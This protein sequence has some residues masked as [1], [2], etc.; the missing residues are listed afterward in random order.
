ML[1]KNFV[2]SI[3][4]S[5]LSIIL[6]VSCQ[7]S[8]NAGQ[9]GTS[10]GSV[11]I[12]GDGTADG[13]AIDIDGDGVAD[14]IDTD[15]DGLI[16][17]EWSDDYTISD[18]ESDST[19]GESDSTSGETDSTSGETDTTSG[20]TDT[21][22]PAEVTNFKLTNVGKCT[23]SS[24]W[25]YNRNIIE[26]SWDDPS[27]S[28]LAK[29]IIKYGDYST[30]ISKGEGSC[31]LS[32]IDTFDEFYAITLKTVDNSGNTSSGLENL[33][34]ATS[35]D[36]VEPIY[37]TDSSASNLNTV[38][39]SNKA[40]YIILETDIDLDSYSW[41]TIKNFTGVFDG[42]GHT[43]S[44]FNTISIT[45][46]NNVGFFTYLGVSS[47]YNPVIMNL[48]FKD[49]DLNVSSSSSTIG[50]ISGALGHGDIYNCGVSG[51]LKSTG[52]GVIGGLVALNKGTIENSFSTVAVTTKDGYAGCFVGKT[53]GTILRCYA[54][55]SVT[56][57]ESS[58]N[59]EVNFG[60]FT[61]DA[62]GTITNCYATGSVS[63]DTKVGGFA[64]SISDGAKLTKSYS[65]VQVSGN[66]TTNG[67]AGSKG[68]STVSNCYY[69]SSVAG[70]NSSYASDI[71]LTDSGS[72]NNFDF[73]DI[74][75]IDSSINNG[76]PYLTGMQPE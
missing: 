25:Y 31:T 47:S 52:S 64:G 50:I 65:A 61:G 13:T 9:S 3:L 48:M 8:L 28:D 1:K 33:V 39:N 23:D 69:N 59:S 49:C 37:V 62:G 42:N 17:E 30:E 36:A 56:Y 19:S 75:S 76:M 5:C 57:S 18:N 46:S 41:S 20:E 38:L 34:F 21:T 35:N 26:F 27:D 10:I 66:A 40:G 7:D 2:L 24:S 63:G 4:I 29:I 12:D 14:G 55:G 44:N 6:F 71:I 32:D 54:S 15:G 51:S 58:S 11:D 22:A 70:V 74:W 67:F 72:F 73:D 53:Y 43:I 60:G 68:D 45:D 16:D